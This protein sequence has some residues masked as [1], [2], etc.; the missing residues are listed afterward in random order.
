MKI[1]RKTSILFAVVFIFSYMSNIVWANDAAGPDLSTDYNSALNISDNLQVSSS[2]IEAMS[3]VQLND[4]AVSLEALDSGVI[5]QTDDQILKV[6]TEKKSGKTSV[7][8]LHLSSSSDQEESLSTD[9]E[10]KVSYMD[11]DPQSVNMLRLSASSL[12]NKTDEAWDGSFSIKV[13]LRVSYSNYN[14]YLHLSRAYA[15]SYCTGSSGIRVTQTK[16]YYNATGAIYK[17][18]EFYKNGVLGE[19][20][21]SS[22]PCLMPTGTTVYRPHT[23]G[24]V[25][26]VTGTRGIQVQVCLDFGW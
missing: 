1:F 22:S 25:C 2:D 26:E 5:I 19:T 12:L 17:N 18:G 9:V 20:F 10:L 14:D 3:Y 23:A 11:A 8:A 6:K 4:Q 24:V 13:S 16:I 15:E 7:Q 21:Y